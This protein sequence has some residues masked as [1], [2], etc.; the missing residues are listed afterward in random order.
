M[1]KHPSFHPVTAI[2]PAYNEAATIA[3]L[4]DVLIQVPLLSEIIVVD[5]HSTDATREIVRMHALRD[6]RIRLVSLPV[7]LGKGGALAAGAKERNND[8]VVFL[9][10]DLVNVQPIHIL[11]L[12]EP[13]QNGK[14]AMTLGIFRGGRFQTDWSHRVTPFLSGQRCL[15]WG[16]FKNTPGFSDARWGAEVSLSL[17]ARQNNL[18]VK[19]I[20]WKGVTHVMRPEKNKG[21]MRYW[22]H[23]Q[24]WRDIGLYLV[25]RLYQQ[26]KTTS[27]RPSQT[28]HHHLS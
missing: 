4:L 2:I 18:K 14:Y 3:S 27:K 12:I 17:Y 9:D 11:N 8:L 6:E 1:I 22:S 13:V 15:N 28:A 16:V 19:R 7:N 21:I 10:A 23:V 5:D 26:K 20:F 25:Q 24:M